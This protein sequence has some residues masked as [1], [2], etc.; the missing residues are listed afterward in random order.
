M[1]EKA[2]ENLQKGGKNAQKTP[3]PRM[4]IGRQGVWPGECNAIC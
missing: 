4:K 3:C 1:F 2:V